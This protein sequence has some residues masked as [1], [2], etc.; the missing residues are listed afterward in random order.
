VGSA[1]RKSGAAHGGSVRMFGIAAVSGK[2]ERRALA[3]SSG[4]S[5]D[6][7]PDKALAG[8]GQAVAAACAARS[9]RTGSARYCKARIV[10]ISPAAAVATFSNASNPGLAMG[11]RLHRRPAAGTRSAA[12]VLGPVTREDLV[13]LED[14]SRPAPPPLCRA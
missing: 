10:G 9:V 3:R 11:T 5:R 7:L 6:H 4:W 12:E 14:R 2:V 13:A 1:K 8:L